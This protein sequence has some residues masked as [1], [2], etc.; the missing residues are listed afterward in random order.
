V[1]HPGVSVPTSPGTPIFD[2][3]AQSAI[4]QARARVEGF[5]RPRPPLTPEQRQEALEA[6]EE[7]AACRFCAG[8]HAGASTPACPRL[9]TFELNGDG[10][11]I[12]GSFWPEGISDAA[13]E[14]DGEGAVRAVTFHK[15]DEWDT[16]Q[17]VRAADAAEEDAGELAGDAG[18]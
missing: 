5:T 6:A 10:A 7:G 8:L 18:D 1:T 13:V 3:V 12:K 15:H 11:V 4:A 16:S 9:A 2:Q 17:I 14:L